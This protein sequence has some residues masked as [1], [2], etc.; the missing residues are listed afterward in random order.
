MA[1][2]DAVL[3]TSLHEALAALEDEGALAIGGGTSVAL[4]LRNGLLDPRRLVFLARVRELHESQH[5][6][7]ALRLGAGTTLRDCARHP[8]LR[9]A[10]PALAGAAAGV[11]N[12]RVRAV[13]TLG[14]ALAHGDPRQDL[15]PVLLALGATIAISSTTGTTERPLDGFFGGF[16]D[17]AL[18][19]GELIRS[20]QIP[21]VAGRR[22]TY[23]RF[24]PASADDYPT[25]GV[26]A[27]VSR[28][29]A[30]NLA[31]L[32]LG[33][34]GVGSSALLVAGLSPLVGRP[35]DPDTI[36]AAAHQAQECAAPISDQ[37]GSADYK[38]EMLAVIT[39]RALEALR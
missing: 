32:A 2:L 30:G 5:D 1:E 33:L 39:R 16:L 35:L 28:D 36:A 31:E 24:T 23:V 29:A 4:L 22:C 13:A 21:L 37:R 11:G 14:G 27:V 7:N 20:V 12:A 18:N 38:R 17:T 19:E 26:A 3:P 25:V 6:E 10:L 15:P 34:A 9:R 8:E